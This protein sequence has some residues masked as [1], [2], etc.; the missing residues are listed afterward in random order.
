M[1][2]QTIN[3]QKCRKKIP[4][5]NQKKEPYLLRDKDKNSILLL[6]RKLTN[7]KIVW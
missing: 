3:N 2:F 4:N 1:Y 5:R 6:L 7:K